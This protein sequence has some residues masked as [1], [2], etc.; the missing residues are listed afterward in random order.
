M[1]NEEYS[2]DP[3]FKPIWDLNKL[4]SKS[5]EQVTPGTEGS[6]TVGFFSVVKRPDAEVD[7]LELVARIKAATKG[8]YGDEP[9][10]RLLE[11]PSYIELGGWIGDQGVA[12]GLMGLGAILGLWDIITPMTLGIEGKQADDMMG[13]GFIMIAPGSESLLRS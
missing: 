13:T 11:G 8:Y 7:A 4:V 5:V 3:K 10:E 6:V 9:V 12:L 2:G 1:S